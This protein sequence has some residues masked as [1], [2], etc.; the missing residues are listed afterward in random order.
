MTRMQNG[1]GTVGWWFDTSAL[2]SD[3]AATQIIANA[4]TLARKGL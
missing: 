4:S 3:E 1:F 2:T